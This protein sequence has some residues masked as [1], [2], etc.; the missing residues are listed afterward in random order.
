M[1]EFDRQGY[2]GTITIEYEYN[3]DKSLP[4]V[5]ESAEY[6]YRLSSWIKKD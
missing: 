2:K 6:F 3:W 5:K 1:W 4:E